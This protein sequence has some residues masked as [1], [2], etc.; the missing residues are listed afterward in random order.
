MTLYFFFQKKKY[1]C[2]SGKEYSTKRHLQ[3]HM[4][5]AHAAA[6]GTAETLNC[7]KCNKEYFTKYDLFRHMLSCDQKVFTCVLCSMTTTHEK[8][9]L[10]IIHLIYPLLKHYDEPIL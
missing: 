1:P 9:S 10:R 3:N 4:K 6:V 5:K 8:F 2:E 7:A